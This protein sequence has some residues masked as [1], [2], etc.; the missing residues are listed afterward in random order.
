MSAVDEQRAGDEGEMGADE[1]ITPVDDA[2]PA[3]DDADPERRRA[4]RAEQLRWAPAVVALLAVSLA[5]R[6]WGS[7]QGL[8]YAYNADENAHF[9]PKAIG[10]FGHGWNPHY[11]VNPPAYTYVLHVLF[12]GWFG[13]RAGVSE[14]F[15]RDPT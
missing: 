2:P 1:A 15:A 9:V 8:P 4:R 10:L 11:F 13:G 12:A 3:A 14:S 7:K 6:V 5:L